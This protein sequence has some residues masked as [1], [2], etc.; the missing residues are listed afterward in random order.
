MKHYFYDLTPSDKKKNLPYDYGEGLNFRFMQTPLITY[1]VTTKDELGNINVAPVSLGTYLQGGYFAFSMI[2]GETIKQG[3]FPKDTT[4]NLDVNGECVISYC[5]KSQLLEM[6]ITG[7]P[8][9]TGIDEGEVAGYSYYPS[10]HVSAP[11]LKE[12]PINMEAKVVYSQ[13]FGIIKVFILK[14]LAIHIDKHID[15]LDKK[16]ASRPG[17]LL[18]DPLIEMYLENETENKFPNKINPDFNFRLQMASINADTP[19][20]SEHPDIGPKST[21]VG[22]FEIWMHDELELGRINKNEH[23]EIM[24]LYENWKND[25]NP[26][27]NSTTKKALTDWMK[28]IIWKRS[29]NK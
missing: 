26:E 24:S 19:V 5:T 16:T 27:T 21:W 20:M 13:V 28:E 18:I 11:C 4:N 2:H 9:P 29:L 15:E 25:R 12:L 14:I 22:T 23:N 10:A 3:E 6:R 1:Y 7:C 8:M 17:M